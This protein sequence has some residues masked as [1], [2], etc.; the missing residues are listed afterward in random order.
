MVVILVQFFGGRQAGMGVSMGAPFYS[1]Y[2]AGFPAGVPTPFMEAYA[3]AHKITTPPVMTR[4]SGISLSKKA[5]T[6]I[7]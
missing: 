7:P 4:V 6:I 3:A 1:V 2:F 5:A